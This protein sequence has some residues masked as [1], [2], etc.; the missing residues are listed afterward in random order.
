MDP[1]EQTILAADTEPGPDWWA[2]WRAADFSWAGLAAK[3]WKGWVWDPAAARALPANADVPG[4]VPA[5]LQHQ[6]WAHRD[7]LFIDPG[8]GRAYTVAHLPLEWSDGSSSPKTASSHQ[9]EVDDELSLVIG[10]LTAACAGGMVDLAGVVFAASA[11][12]PT[13]TD[14][15]IELRLGHVHA[16]GS[17][18]IRAEDGG[19]AR[20]AGFRL[21]HSLLQGDLD[22][23]GAVIEGPTRL[24]NGRGTEIAGELNGQGLKALGPV[25]ARFGVRGRALF[26]GAVFEGET[27]FEDCAFFS[28]ADFT[29]ARF[30]RAASFARTIIS[31]DARFVGSTFEGSGVFAGVAFRRD[32]EFHG[33]AFAGGAIFAESVFEGNAWFDG[34]AFGSILNLHGARFEKLAGFSGRAALATDR[35]PQTI[36][37]Q[38][39]AAIDESDRWAGVVAAQDLLAA[40][41]RRSFQTIDA[42]DAVFVRDADFSNR[43][44]LQPSSF[45]GA[46]FLG[47]ARFHGS[48]LHQ[49][50]NFHDARFEALDYEAQSPRARLVGGRWPD[51]ALIA[52]EAVR[53]IESKAPLRALAD[54]PDEFRRAVDP[55]RDEFSE[56]RRSALA[57]VMTPD[58]R[59][60]TDARLEALEA[61]FRTLKLAMEDTRARLSESRFFKMELRARRRRRDSEVP[62]WERF[63]SLAYGVTADYGDSIARPLIFFLALAMAFAFAYWGL[64]ALETESVADWSRLG[65][66]LRYSLS[67]MTPFGAMQEQDSWAW[68][69]G[70]R[71]EGSLFSWS[72]LIRIAATVQSA[73]ALV[74]T[75]LFALA[76]R[77]RFQIV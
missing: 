40:F 16:G 18:R 73:L 10:D 34:A 9:W 2:G 21:E 15:P 19:P 38:R 24:L 6:W 12:I 53:R 37:L 36:D 54:R 68:L 23:E 65:D 59:R 57:D 43:D 72:G 25:F 14:R 42:S 48:R 75:F 52:V 11:L 35:N 62:A 17:L 32:A 45:A 33:A 66:A 4:S 74:L 58:G 56:R 20:L 46:R 49:R 7:A 63:A 67:R 28:R 76:V 71:S 31:N 41:A 39:S 55:V 61:S 30:L 22:V 27:T 70:W 3:P 5:T 64:A 8:D 50:V 1:P 44:I 29:N 26:E 47:D 69:D 60:Q 13:P 51:V 77:R